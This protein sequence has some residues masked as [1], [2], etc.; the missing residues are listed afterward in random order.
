MSRINDILEANKEFV[1]LVNEIPLVDEVRIF[2]DEI[3]IEY[4]RNM[5]NSR[6]EDEKIPLFHMIKVFNKIDEI[7]GS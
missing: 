2:A 3:L 6:F 4:W 5:N 1:E 7:F